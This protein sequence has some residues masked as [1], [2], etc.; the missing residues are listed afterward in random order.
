MMDM[1]DA[2]LVQACSFMSHVHIRQTYS[3]NLHGQLESFHAFESSYV[4]CIQLFFKTFLTNFVNYKDRF[5]LRHSNGVTDCRVHDSLIYAVHP[6]LR[7]LGS[8]LGTRKGIP[9]TF[10]FRVQGMFQKDNFTRAVGTSEDLA[11]YG[12]LNS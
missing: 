2:S 12:V 4:E 8:T 3:R 1:S 9:H 10:R 7:Q 6:S 11:P 5:S